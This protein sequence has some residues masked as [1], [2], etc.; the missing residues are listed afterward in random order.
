MSV[1]TRQST[2]LCNRP[3]RGQE[4]DCGQR[5]LV[6]T[7]N[8]SMSKQLPDRRAWLSFRR[9]E[10]DP[11]MSRPMMSAL[12][13]GAATA[14]GVPAAP[15]SAVAAELLPSAVAH[16]R[17]RHTAACCGPWG[18]LRLSYVFHRELRTTYGTGFDPRNFDQ[19]EPH[20]YFGLVRAYPRYWV[21][22][23]PVQ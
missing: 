5:D 6:T 2:Y 11:V 22:V 14:A 10:R 21:D 23:E 7:I 13:L 4:E 18:C 15:L 9:T 1:P 20:Y 19:T 17:H 8:S 3:C 12:L 16:A